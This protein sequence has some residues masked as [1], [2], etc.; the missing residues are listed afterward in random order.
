MVAAAG[1]GASAQS[2]P[3]APRPLKAL[4]LASGGYHDYAQLTPYLET[5]LSEMVNVKFDVDMDSSF[6]RLKNKDFARGYDVIVYD[7]C[8]VNTDSA[9]LENA[10]K[11]GTRR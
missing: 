2:L 11:A 8:Q 6:S 1:A 9:V 10:I 7:V 3:S 4:F 5:K